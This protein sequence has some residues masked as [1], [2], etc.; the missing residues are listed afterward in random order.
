MKIFSISWLKFVLL[1][2]VFITG[3]N[4]KLFDYIHTNLHTQNN[5]VSIISYI[6]VYFALMVGIFAL[7]FLPYLS[8]IIMILLVIT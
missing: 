5:D 6:I 4:F 8:K 3:V 7:L 1:S 2:A